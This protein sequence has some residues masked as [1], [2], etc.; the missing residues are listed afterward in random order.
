M[1]ILLQFVLC[2]AFAPLAIGQQ[3]GEAPQL[4]LRHIQVHTADIF[5]RDWTGNYTLSK[6][7]NALH[8]TTHE[9]VVRR[10][11]WL[12]PGQPVSRDIADEIERN[13][14]AMGLF[15]EVEVELVPTGDDDQVDL[16]VTT[17]DK[18]SLSFGGGASYVGGIAGYRA[19]I[20]ESN[21]FGSG[22]RIAVSFSQNS[23]EDHRG[24]VAYTDRHVFDTWHVGTVRFANTDVGDSFGIDL[25]RPIK[26]LADPLGY[27]GAL[28][29]D[30]E[31][32][33]YYRDGESV[34]QVFTRRGELAGDTTWAMGPRDQR[35]YFGFAVRLTDVHH[36]PATGPLAPQIDVPE[37][38]QNL[39][40]GAHARIELID[41]YRKIDG[42]D[43]LDYV[44]DLQLG[45]A[46]TAT[47]GVRWRDEVGIPGAVQP[48]VA[49][50]LDW[51]TELCDEVFVN[52]RGSGTA[53]W[54]AG[55]TVGWRSQLGTWLFAMTG[56]DN[57]IGLSATYDAAE[58][59]QDLPIEFTL[60]EDNGLRGYPARQFSG[61]RRL[62][63]NLENRWDTRL[64]YATF[65]LGIVT[66][67]D[68]G[69]V[70]FD[71]DL[72]S[73][74][75]SVGAGLRL[76][77]KPL[78]GDGILR[79]DVAKPLDDAVGTSDG[80]RVSF[81]VGQVFTFGGNASSLGRL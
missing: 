78:L 4:R 38:T 25:R 24:S 77:S 62:R 63:I 26:H 47:A 66:F 9:E 36:R 72:G 60:G 41:G 42:L 28:R 57:T 5:G 3:Q 53:R 54:D 80:W 29:R 32:V 16:V 49:V 50:S 1:R 71:S 10:E 73:P 15:A 39:Y 6:L 40:V 76:A 81:A 34:A 12:Q 22:N 31:E 33:E 27:G 59:Q 13:L 19:S 43:T 17:R 8:A 48:E 61:T 51:A 20:G 75:E 68:A 52:C 30:E 2:V 69:W 74:Y 70:G 56:S 58:E 65:R 21:L 46:V 55:E 37:D 14:R 35:R 64:E 7:V 23:D 67:F 79:L 11:V 44:Q 18:L 45:L